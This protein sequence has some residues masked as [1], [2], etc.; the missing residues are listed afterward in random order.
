M[1]GHGEECITRP[2]SPFLPS[3]TI[4]TKGNKANVPN[5]AQPPMETKAPNVK[6]HLRRMLGPGIQQWEAKGTTYRKRCSVRRAG[7]YY[8]QVRAAEER[9]AGS[10]RRDPPPIRQHI[11]RCPALRAAVGSP[12]V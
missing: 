9:Q 1:T 11:L 4:H 3:F 10:K 8:P 7:R 6:L 5:S 2:D 12:G